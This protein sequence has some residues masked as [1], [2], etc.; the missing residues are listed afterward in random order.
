MRRWTYH[1]QGRQKLL[2]NCS[3]LSEAKILN[4]VLLRTADFEQCSSHSAVTNR[5]T[6]S[7]ASLC[8]VRLGD[9]LFK[10]HDSTS[11]LPSFPLW[12]RDGP[13]R[14]PRAQ[15]RSCCDR[16]CQM[17]SARGRGGWREAAFPFPAPV[18]LGPLVRTRSRWVMI[19][20]NSPRGN[21]TKACLGLKW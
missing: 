21:K 13:P 20:V 3:I 8:S 1:H 12:V 9:Q 4:K 17:W 14:A 16:A 19:T 11:R 6:T 18:Q 10:E 5:H 15:V 7:Q 2:I